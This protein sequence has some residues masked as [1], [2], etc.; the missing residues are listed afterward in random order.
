MK[1]KS[2]PAD[3]PSME[4]K[5]PLMEVLRDERESRSGMVAVPAP[6]AKR[7]ASSSTK[8]VAKRA[9]SSG[10]KTPQSTQ[11]S[12]APRSV[13]AASSASASS[14]A[15]KVEDSN[16]E[17]GL[18]SDIDADVFDSLVGSSEGA[19]IGSRANPILS[20]VSHSDSE[21]EYPCDLNVEDFDVPQ[22]KGKGKARALDRVDPTPAPIKGEQKVKSK[23]KYSDNFVKKVKNKKVV[24]LLDSH[25]DLENL[26]DSISYSEHG[27]LGHWMAN[28]DTYLKNL[29]RV[30][31]LRLSER[32]F[33]LAQ[34]FDGS[35]MASRNFTFTNVH[36]Q[37]DCSRPL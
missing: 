24:E 21:D 16:D 37:E 5:S 36:E 34:C 31:K 27:M 29:K 22:V 1:L 10:R 14:E 12:F 6:L 33:H 23:K 9:K 30:V 13:T 2:P 26:D 25:S 18:D 15:L 32:A 11:S 8:S 17:F 20:W 4:L 7:P 28:R 35:I 19:E 3:A